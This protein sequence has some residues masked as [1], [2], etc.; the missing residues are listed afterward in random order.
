[1]QIKN[2]FDSETIL[3]ISKS[4]LYA[5]L[6]GISAGLVCYVNTSN[7]RTSVLTGL[8]TLTSFLVN[9]PIEYRKGD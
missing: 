2:K 4:F 1:M 3:N 5:S 9:V 6:S 7:V 8:A